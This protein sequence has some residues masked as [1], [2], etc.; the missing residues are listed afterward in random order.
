[1]GL[2]SVDFKFLDA[3]R[4][5]MRAASSET[6]VKFSA[7]YTDSLCYSEFILPLPTKPLLAHEQT[8]TATL[9]LI[10]LWAIKRHP[11]NHNKP[12]MVNAQEELMDFL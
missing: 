5:R 2:V 3:F 9:L 7:K 6:S 11:P 4:V 1:M 10:T 8:H 12:E